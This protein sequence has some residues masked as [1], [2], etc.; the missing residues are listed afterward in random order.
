MIIAAYSGCGKTTFASKTWDSIDL[1][2][3]PYKYIVPE[4]FNEE[5]AESGKACY[6]YP[7]HPNWPQN[8]ISAI[9][10]A[11]HRYRYVVIPPVHLVLQALQRFQIPY[12]LCYP[13]RSA[14]EEYRRR[15]RQRGNGDMF[16]HI[17]IGHWDDYLDRFEQD[18]Y[19]RHL[20]LK[21]GEYLLDHRDF[22][23]DCTDEEESVIR[24]DYDLNLQK[25]VDEVFETTGV[26]MEEQV[27]QWILWT[28]EH[29]EVLKLWKEKG[30]L[31]SPGDFVSLYD[32]AAEDTEC[33]SLISGDGNSSSTMPQQA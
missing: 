21:E 3:V 2:C 6:G 18:D 11:Y 7:P 19:A 28:G 10:T 23:A 27:R 33:E 16:E 17:F 29:P 9:L 14:R 1:V 32:H 20:V 13:Q 26:C 24:I 8:Y 12:I 22:I 5:D 30:Q 4:E 15:F 31:S 25:K